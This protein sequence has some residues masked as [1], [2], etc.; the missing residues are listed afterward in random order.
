MGIDI[1]G[2]STKDSTPK[3]KNFYLLL[4]FRRVPL[5]LCPNMRRKES[6]WSNGLMLFENKT[7]SGFVGTCKALPCNPHYHPLTNKEGC[8]F[9][10][11]GHA[12]TLVG[13][14]HN[15]KFLASSYSHPL[16]MLTKRT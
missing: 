9:V 16:H 4:S 11:L 10:L 5:S 13:F 3:V 7:N 6:G 15:A 8:C 2:I 14:Q 12:C 1:P